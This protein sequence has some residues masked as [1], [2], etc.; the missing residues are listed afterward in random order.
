M[1]QITNISILYNIFGVRIKGLIMD[2]KG[3]LEREIR[4]QIDWPLLIF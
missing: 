4:K 3:S 1:D 2:T